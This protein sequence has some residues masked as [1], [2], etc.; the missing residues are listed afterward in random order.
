MSSPNLESLKQFVPAPI[1]RAARELHSQL[2]LRRAIDQVARLPLGTLPTPDLLRELQTYWA[3][4]GFAARIDFLTEVARQAVSTSEPILECGSGLTTLLMGL[5]AGRRGIE[6]Y[7]LEHID[8][9]HARVS[10]A[11]V[12]FEIPNVRILLTPIRD[13]EGYAWYDACLNEL[14][15][16]FGLAICDGPPGETQGGRYGLLPVIGDRLPPGAVI[17]LDDTER[18]GEVEALRRWQREAELSVSMHD[19]DDGSFA[20]ITRQAG[21]AVSPLTL[22]TG[23]DSPQVS[24]IIPAYNVAPYI[25]ETLESVFA[26][27]FSDY[28]I[29]VVN[30]GSSDTEEFEL[31]IKPYLGRI[32]YLR[33]ENKGASVAR[34]T[35]LEA[36]RG[37]YVAFLD[38]DDLWLPDYLEAQMKFIR[39]RG[40]DLAC[41]DATFFGDAASEGQTYMDT[42]M[43]TAPPAGEVTF[44]QLV[45]AA[46]SLIT[47]GIVARRQPI[48]GVGLFDEG[49]RNAQDLDLWLRLAR[50]GARLSYQR[51]AL[52]KYRCRTDGLTGDIVN[53]HRR[54]L[55]V[56]DKIEHSYDLGP[57]ERE[58]V[59]RVIKNRRALLE[60]ELGKLHAAHGDFAQARESFTEA[61]RLR[62]TWKTRTGF[63]LNRLA[64]RLLQ[65]VCLYRQ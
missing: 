19:S 64:P 3:N 28:E 42:L 46:R 59:L 20:I 58:E 39:E 49:L 53:S 50:S 40:C 24:V 10:E 4:D 61:N 29:I 65:A 52:L 41:A 11:V 30:D 6:V 60:F 16:R 48:M 18:S 47:S 15:Q 27:T 57:Q 23:A 63:W 12:Q 54:E 8:E 33:Q 22:S 31:A 32:R 7:S 37:D 56:F 34:N 43:P 5:L 62:P 1:K 14:P 26:Q 21:S 17:L 38:A 25:A 13:F 45:D 55:R 2:K 44:L 35:G 36:A 51:R 9:W